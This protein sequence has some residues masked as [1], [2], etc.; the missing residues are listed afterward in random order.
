[1]ADDFADGDFTRAPRWQVVSGQFTVAW[2]G[3]LL[4]EARTDAEVRTDTRRTGSSNGQRSSGDLV[5]DLLEDVLRPS[6]KRRGSEGSDASGPA[7][8]IAYSVICC[9]SPT[10]SSTSPLRATPR[11]HH[12]ERQTKWA[13]KPRDSAETLRGKLVDGRD[14]S[15][16][17]VA[18]ETGDAAPQAV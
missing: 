4:S 1:V 5:G 9:K 7:V 17:V 18:I 13:L 3:G 6:D 2:D 10:W 15:L 12:E 8:L 11:R 14:V 16:V